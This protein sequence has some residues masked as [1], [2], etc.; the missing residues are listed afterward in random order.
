[1]TSIW[2]SPRMTKRACGMTGRGGVPRVRSRTATS[3]SFRDALPEEELVDESGPIGG[4]GGVQVSSAQPVLDAQAWHSRKL[5]YVRKSG[6]VRG[7]SEALRD[8]PSSGSIR[9]RH[10][11][12]RVRRHPYQ[13]RGRRLLPSA[14]AHGAA[15]STARTVRA[16]L[17][18]VGIPAPRQ[19]R[20][21]QIPELG[22]D[23]PEKRAESLRHVM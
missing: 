5:R 7:D 23:R 13:V 12:L 6:L 2:R 22:L 3:P 11:V 4:L 9:S 20:Y 16:R 19:R 8:R 17:W 10:T 1:M 21:R 14:P 18:T 15:S